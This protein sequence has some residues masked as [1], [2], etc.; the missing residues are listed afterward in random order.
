MTYIVATKVR[1]QLSRKYLEGGTLSDTVGTDESEHLTRARSGQTVKLEGVCGVTMCYLRVEVGWQVNDSDS[2]EG[3]SRRQLSLLCCHV[4]TAAAERD[5]VLLDTDTTSDAQEL[6][7][8]GD[9]V[10]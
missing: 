7:D 10:G 3:T 2:F 5:D 6:G 8:E 9:L 4:V 1:L